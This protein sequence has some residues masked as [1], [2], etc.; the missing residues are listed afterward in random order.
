MKRY[1]DANKIIT[2]AIKERKF[3]FQKEDLIK[4]EE[5]A[6][7]TVYK[8]LAEFIDSQ[9]TADVEEVKHGKWTR[10]TGRYE[11]LFECSNCYFTSNKTTAYCEV[12]GA[13]M[14]GGG[15]QRT[16]VIK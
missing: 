2:D 8:D 3:V 1:I 9:P 6:V 12:C 15:N 11:G 10:M 14:D 16:V 5:V 4:S 13:K 7:R